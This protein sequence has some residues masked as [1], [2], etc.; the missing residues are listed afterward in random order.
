MNRKARPSRWTNPGRA[1]PGR[2]QTC[3]IVNSPAWASPV[4]PQIR[5]AKPMISPM[6]LERWSWCTLPVRVSPISGTWSATA[7]S[8]WLRT[9]GLTEATRPR[10]VVRMS[11]SGKIETNAE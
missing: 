3:S 6:M 2:F 10:I 8:T 4:A 11:S 1:G 7:S 9:D 5:P